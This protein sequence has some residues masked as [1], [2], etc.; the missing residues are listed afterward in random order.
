M[1]GRRESPSNIAC[2]TCRDYQVSVINSRARDDDTIYRRR[3][4][5]SC[6]YTWTTYETAMSGLRHNTQTALQEMLSEFELLSGEDRKAIR[7]MIRQL[8]EARRIASLLIQAT[9]QELPKIERRKHLIAVNPFDDD[10][11]IQ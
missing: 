7:L 10:N 6:G 3:R 8:A 1:Y 2:P 9:D 5:G 4:C 11:L